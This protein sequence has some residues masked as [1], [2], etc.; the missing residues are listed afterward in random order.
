MRSRPTIA[1]ESGMPERAQA[2]NRRLLKAAERLLK[3]RGLHPNFDRRGVIRSVAG[4]LR[5]IA[6]QFSATPPRFCTVHADGARRVAA[7][8]SETSVSFRL[9]PCPEAG[10]LNFGRSETRAR[11]TVKTWPTLALA[12]EFATKYNALKAEIDK[13]DDRHARAMKP[14]RRR[15]D[16]TVTA[17]NRKAERAAAAAAGGARQDRGRA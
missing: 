8:D 3:L 1:F 5:A 17:M 11:F 2:A 15:I 13:R 6:G 10:R 16:R 12:I 9:L 7:I 4:E 14:L